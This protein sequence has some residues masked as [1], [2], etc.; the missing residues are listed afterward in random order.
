MTQDSQGQGNP[1]QEP[2]EAVVA[3]FKALLEQRLI[4]LDSLDTATEQNRKPVELDQQSI[5]RLSRMDAMQQQAMSFASQGRRHGER[6]LVQAALARIA[7]G[8]FGWCAAC[9]EAIA[10]RRLAIDPTTATCIHCATS[11]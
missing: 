10:P 2:S 1:N 11:G 3:E 5:G 8:E 6:R 9:G 4:D 7:D